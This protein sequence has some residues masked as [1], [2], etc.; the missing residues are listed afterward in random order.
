MT[1]DGIRDLSVLPTVWRDA[2]PAANLLDTRKAVTHMGP[3]Q[4]IAPLSSSSLS[5]APVHF[6]LVES[7]LV[8]LLIA[9]TM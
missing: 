3:D 9:D 5:S 8:V 6:I 7:I 2:R 1:V 4:E